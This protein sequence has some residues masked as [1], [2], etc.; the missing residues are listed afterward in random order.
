MSHDHQSNGQPKQRVA[1]GTPTGGQFAATQRDESDVDLYADTLPDEYARMGYEAGLGH[2]ITTLTADAEAAE[3]ALG[4]ARAHRE[5]LQ[6]DFETGDYYRANPGA[7]WGEAFETEQSAYAA[8]EA[9]EQEV[10]RLK[11]SLKSASYELS[12]LHESRGDYD[13]AEPVDTRSEYERDD[14]DDLTAIEF[15]IDRVRSR[16]GIVAQARW[17]EHQWE[18]EAAANALSEMSCAPSSA[19]ENVQ[20]DGQ[21]INDRDIVAS[22]TLGALEDSPFRD[23]VHDEIDRIHG[24]PP[25]R[26]ALARATDKVEGLTDD[27]AAWKQSLADVPG[28]NFTNPTYA[29]EYVRDLREGEARTR[30]L[31]KFAQED[32]AALAALDE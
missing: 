26:R 27:V 29:D 11:G 17:R 10:N 14:H 5:Q 24:R 19:A 18:D 7:D 25:Q 28:F 20:D 23:E 21:D 1:S 30:R 32:A 31:L 4:A 2:E 6:A 13:T 3:T 12:E 22:F 8:E 9:A 15:A 16:H